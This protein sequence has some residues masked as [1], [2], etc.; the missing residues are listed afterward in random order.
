MAEEW[1]LRSRGTSHGGGVVD[2]DRSGEGE[3]K[4][5]VGRKK[6]ILNDKWT[7][8]TKISGIRFSSSTGDEVV[9]SIYLNLYVLK[10]IGMELN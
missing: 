3:R 5:Q 2:V 6:I 7:S 10:V 4:K 1:R 8:H 9:W